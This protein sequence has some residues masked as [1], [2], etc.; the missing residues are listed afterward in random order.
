MIKHLYVA[1]TALAF[2]HSPGVAAETH[3]IEWELR[4]P[5]KLFGNFSRDENYFT[6]DVDRLVWDYRRDLYVDAACQKTPHPVTCSELALGASRYQ[7]MRDLLLHPRSKDDHSHIRDAWLATAIH[8]DNA[9]R[10]YSPRIFRKDE[11]VGV[12]VRLNGKETASLTCQWSRDG[13]RLDEWRVPCGEWLRTFNIRRG[14]KSSTITVEIENG[15]TQTLS[16]K[17]TLIHERLIVGFGDSFASG[18]GNPDIAVRLST[19]ETDKHRAFPLPL[20]R[21]VDDMFQLDAAQWLDRDCHRSLLGAQQMAAMQFSARR[22]RE[23]TIFLG[24]ACSGAEILEGIIG[25]YAGTGETSTFSRN[26]RKRGDYD[27]WDSSQI[28]QLLKVLCESE[29]ARLRSFEDVFTRRAVR[30]GNYASVLEKKFARNQLDTIVTACPNGRLKMK[31][32]AVLLSVGGN[33]IGFSKIVAASLAEGV[34]QRALLGVADQTLSPTDAKALIE[35]NL[36]KKYKELDRV[37]QT[38]LN[39]SDPKKVIV[40]TYPNPLTDAEGNVCG[41]SN[42]GMRRGLE[43]FP[44][45]GEARLSG[46]E[47]SSIIRN[48]V[49]PLNMAIRAAPDRNGRM[50]TVADSHERRVIRHGICAEGRLSPED[51]LSTKDYM[52]K[53]NAYA[54]TTRWFR[55]INDSFL[56]QNQQKVESELGTSLLARISDEVRAPYL[57]I[58]G[59]IHPNS[60]GAAANADAY[61]QKLEQVIPAGR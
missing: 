6:K 56:I 15:N 33:D 1:F 44:S 48:V 45:R 61:L 38:Y 4:H 24:F 53:F 11:Y 41:S 35:R 47:S 55:T 16:G 14:P 17:H 12:K 32:D 21:A 60:I 39:I 52:F 50:W 7:K 42:G 2:A 27:R 29:P 51:S 54:P 31:I 9:Q 36:P 58:Y 20:R 18:E 8:W 49:E 23:E 34:A 3:Q 25:P 10:S 59:A 22:P 13:V 57:K 43:G 46:N 40:T 26:G 28:N 37:L 5:F 30:S 19:T